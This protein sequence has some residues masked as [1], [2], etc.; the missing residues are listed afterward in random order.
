[1]SSRG[2]FAL[3]SIYRS[4]VAFFRGFGL[5][6]QVEQPYLNTLVWNGT[7][8]FVLLNLRAFKMGVGFWVF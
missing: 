5:P 2:A 4:W 1:M 8:V 3:G 6:T 7:N